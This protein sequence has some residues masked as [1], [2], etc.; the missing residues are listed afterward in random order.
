MK[1]LD[2]TLTSRPATFAGSSPVAR[3]ERADAPASST[4]LWQAALLGISGDALLRAGL[5]GPGLVAWVCVLGM[6]ALALTWSA[7]RRMPREAALWFGAA[8]LFAVLTAWRDSDALQALDILTVIASLGM[9]ALALRDRGTALWAPRL[10][11]TSWAGK[12]LVA[13]V[14]RGVLPMALRQLFLAHDEPVWKRRARGVARASLIIAGLVTVFGSLLRSADPI[15]ARLMRLPDLD[16]ALVASHVVLAGFF[17]WIAG[18][19][20]YG[21]LVAHPAASRA[22]DQ[23]PVR[24]GALEVTT[25][26][27]TLNVLFGAFVLT[28]LGWFFGGEKFLGATTGLTA[29]EYARQ[30]FFQMMWVA[31]LV[32][33]LLLATRAALLPEPALARRHTALSVPVVGLLGAMILSAALRMRLY[34]HYFGLSTDRLTT[35]VFMGWLLFVL[36]L[37]AL[38]VLRGRGRAFVGGSVLSGLTVLAALH[39]MP[40]DLLVARVN[41]ARAAK[42][43]SDSS[44]KLDM[45]Y[46]AWLS[47]D[48]VDLATA[49]T[50]APLQRDAQSDA[51]AAAG[52]CSAAQTLLDRWG[53]DS[54]AVRRR[55]DDGAWRIWNAGESHAVRVVG[56]NTG[57]LL[58]V[59]H[60]ACPRAR[61]A[62]KPASS[63]AIS[64]SND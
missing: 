50:L 15:F 42:A 60:D 16:F 52:R 24:L 4:I 47:A 26:L 57:A 37:L 48:A 30:G 17:A 56:A 41:V 10:R 20:A 22:P 5:H 45:R 34:V 11:D 39:V 25:A 1:T 19:W 49:A 12:A 21:A 18:G 23:L 54:R 8:L 3:A 28:Q 33:P 31:V 9:A 27:G 36:A 51:D 14:L 46:L 44:A 40:P 13:S 53:P 29:A 64:D 63:P 55:D 6:A 61:A 38:T 32:I 2:G 43:P 59:R 7:R 35:L 62:S 58:R